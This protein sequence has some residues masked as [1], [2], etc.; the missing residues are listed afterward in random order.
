MTCEEAID[1][2]LERKKIL[3]ATNQQIA[4]ASNVP[5]TTID[6]IFRKET[7]NPSFQ[8]IIDIATAVGY[9][10]APR[11]K[12][13]VSADDEKLKQI[14]YIYEKRCEALEKESRLKTVQTNM[15][16]AE[17]DRTIQ[18]KNQ[19]ISRLFNS[20]V[21]LGLGVMLVLLADVCIRGIGWFP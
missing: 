6:R 3:N 12:E 16:L 21:I 20:L 2:I 14:I 8:T 17:K 1:G 9:E 13:P 4:D 5:K 11:E 15:L 7:P 18:A 10:F 19:W